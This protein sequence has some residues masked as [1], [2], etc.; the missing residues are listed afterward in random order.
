MNMNQPQS[1]FLALPS[2]ENGSITCL[3]GYQLADGSSIKLAVLGNKP[4]SPRTD[5]VSVRVVLEFPKKEGRSP[6]GRRIIVF[7]PLTLAVTDTEDE[8][9]G[10]CDEALL[11]W[12]KTK[13]DLDLA[14][15]T[16]FLAQRMQVTVADGSTKSTDSTIRF[17]FTLNLA[18]NGMPARPISRSM[19]YDGNLIAGFFV[20]SSGKAALS[21][22]DEDGKEEGLSA[23]QVIDTLLPEGADYP[24][25]PSW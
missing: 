4:E 23:K 9:G 22:F 17:V 24:P 1:D 3:D 16:N 20:P 2:G 8:I 10:P 6:K 5:V 7:D 11:Q 25:Y 14:A 21:A 18:A 15:L 19:L 13:T 12:C